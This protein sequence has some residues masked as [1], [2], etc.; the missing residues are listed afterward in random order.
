MFDKG[1]IKHNVSTWGAPILFVK[2]KCGTLRFCIYYSALN[3]VTIKNKPWPRIDDLFDQLQSASV[4]FK[5]DLQF[6]YH[7]LRFKCEDVPKT[8][9]HTRYEHYEFLVMPFGL[10]NAPTNFMN[11]MNWIFKSY[12]D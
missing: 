11:I 2:K 3:K 5:I 10:T 7:Q 1:F 6:D 4:F 8:T 12:L 9:F